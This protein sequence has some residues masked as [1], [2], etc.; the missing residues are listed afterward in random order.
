MLSKSFTMFYYLKKRSNSEQEKL[1][2]YLRLTV[3]G[4]RIEVATKRD[5]EPSKW[6][7]SSGRK[8]GSKEDVRLLNA[9][10]DTLQNK[11]YDIHRELIAQGKEITSEVIKGKLTGTVD[12]PKMIIELFQEHNNK[13]VTLVGTEYARGTLIRYQTSLDHTR[14][15][16]LWKFKSVFGN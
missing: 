16:I 8:N 11:I 14:N 9:Y 13:M 5:C 1:P 2:I 3:D 6:N 10:L 15:F 4:K 12:K 7:S